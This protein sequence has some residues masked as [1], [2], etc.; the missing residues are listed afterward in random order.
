MNQQKQNLQNKKNLCI[1]CNSKEIYFLK[2]Q[3]CKLCYKRKWNKENILLKRKHDLKYVHSEKGKIRD[4]K[5]RA[6]KNK[7]IEL[8][9]QEEWEYKKQDAGGTCPNCKLY[10]G[11]NNLQLDHIFPISKAENNR[12]YFIDDIQ[13]LCKN[14][15]VRKGATIQNE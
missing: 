12:I 15:N 5:R 11:L 7:I 9:T 1:K 3:L 13:P 8:F 2:H 10:V 14:C 6:N 4:R